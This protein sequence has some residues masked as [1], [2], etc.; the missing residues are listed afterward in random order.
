[1]LKLIFDSIY[2]YGDIMLLY[3]PEEDTKSRSDRK[4][5]FKQPPWMTALTITILISTV[6]KPQGLIFSLNNVTQTTRLFT[7][8]PNKLLCKFQTNTLKTQ[9]VVFLGWTEPRTNLF[10]SFTLVLNIIVEFS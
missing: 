6:V 9:Q 7:Q 8:Q 3:Q 1:M 2:L 5:S 10:W 4:R